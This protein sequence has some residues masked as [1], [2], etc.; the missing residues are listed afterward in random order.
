MVWPGG[1]HSAAPGH[2][3]DCSLDSELLLALVKS[4]ENWK[5]AR[6]GPVN[7]GNIHS[8]SVAEEC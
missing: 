3:G 2:G 6:R 4:V 5:E 1:A 7:R 8:P